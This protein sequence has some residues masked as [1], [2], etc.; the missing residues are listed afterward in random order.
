MGI[1]EKLDSVR[2]VYTVGLEARGCL[3]SRRSESGR[4]VFGKLDGWT[5]D[6]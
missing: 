2:I 5:L 4:L 3:E 6:A 1:L